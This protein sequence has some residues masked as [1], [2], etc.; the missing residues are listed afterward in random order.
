ML[1]GMRLTVTGQGLWTMEGA[2]RSALMVCDYGK[3][4][5]LYLG[6]DTGRCV[7]RKE[8]KRVRK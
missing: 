7:K 5:T 4:G 3:R 8:S 2:P 1:E 6:V